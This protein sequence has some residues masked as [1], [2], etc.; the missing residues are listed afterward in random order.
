MLA[1]IQNLSLDEGLDLAVN[2][3]AMARE[4]EDCK[5]GIDAFLNKKNLNW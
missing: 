3:N 5:K 1:E 4:S 2:K